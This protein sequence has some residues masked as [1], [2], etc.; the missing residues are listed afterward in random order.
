[1]S[2]YPNQYG[3]V[4]PFASSEIDRQ[5]L[6]VIVRF[7]NS[8]YAWMAAGLAVTA[9]VAWYTASSPALTQLLHGPLI[10]VAIIAEFGLVF[11]ISGAINRLSATT[12]TVLFIIFA[13]LNGFTLSSL[14]FIYTAAAVG[15]AFAV[16]AGLF[17]VM[18]LYGMIT[19][20]DLTGLGSMLFMGLMGV[21]IAS[22]VSIFFHSTILSVIINY[23]AAFIF[24][25]LIAYDTQRLKEMAI[26]TQN[27]GALAAR[28][29]VVG[30]LSLYL[31]FINLVIIMLQLM[32]GN[33]RN[34]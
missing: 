31:N 4:S 2:Q 13:A 16:T 22:I 17:A 6:G 19:R 14:L 33:R 32:G 34:D 11:A 15:S 1:M 7:F 20:R 25:G 24:I 27:N 29:S 23:V 30:A 26:A 9:V 18:S 21:V 8:V 10:F 12:A 28:L 5:Q 3:P